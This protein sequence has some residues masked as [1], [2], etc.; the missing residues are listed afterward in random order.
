MHANGSTEDGKMERLLQG[1]YKTM[2]RIV[3]ILERLAEQK[4]AK[5]ITNL[6][7]VERKPVCSIIWF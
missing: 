1:L 6:P 7:E 2:D 4:E 3:E 5:V